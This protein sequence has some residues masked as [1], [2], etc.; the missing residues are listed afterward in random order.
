MR[1][2]LILLLSLGQYVS[3][4]AEI[5][6]EDKI[7]N[8]LVTSIQLN[9]Q[10][11]NYLIENGQPELVNRTIYFDYNQMLEDEPRVL[12]AYASEVADLT[13]EFPKTKVFRP[14]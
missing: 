7:V 14:L 9:E 6:Q 13:S 2:L 3:W 4:S 10:Y 11:N 1:A 12:K 5:S 8:Y